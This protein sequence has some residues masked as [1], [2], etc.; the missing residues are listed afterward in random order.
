MD[1][2]ELYNIIDDRKRNPQ[3]GS[4]TNKLLN[5]EE[6]AYRKLN[7]EV[8]ELIYACLKQDKEN[9]IYEAADVLYH[10]LVVLAKNDVS[11]DEVFK[12]LESR[13]K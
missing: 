8:Y 6:K 5:H 3:E 7:E 2:R 9:I 10:L 11:I 12:E 13:K 1:L 4:Y